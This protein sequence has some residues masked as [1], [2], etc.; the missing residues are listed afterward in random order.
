MQQAKL[1]CKTLLYCR[2]GA[3]LFFRPIAIA[4]LDSSY[5][6]STNDFV[7]FIFFYIQQLNSLTV[8]TFK[9][10]SVFQDRTLS[11]NGYARAVFKL[12]LHQ[13]KAFT[14]IFNTSTGERSS[15]KSC[16]QTV[17]ESREAFILNN[18]FFFHYFFSYLQSPQ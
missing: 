17:Q 7:K 3:V 12:Y 14:Q 2:P 9:I 10:H 11:L 1:N 16:Y 18:L 5:Q 13:N 6:I 4:Y 15:C 8:K